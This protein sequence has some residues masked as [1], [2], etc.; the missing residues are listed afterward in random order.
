MYLPVSGIYCLIFSCLWLMKLEIIGNGKTL[1]ASDC[2]LIKVYS[3]ALCIIQWT[4]PWN[5]E[6]D[7]LA[8]P[9]TCLMLLV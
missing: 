8:G 6:A 3:G 4:E 2:L 7:W 5:P 1:A 9:T